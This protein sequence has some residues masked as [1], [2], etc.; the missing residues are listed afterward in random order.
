MT[1]EELINSYVQHDKAE[2]EEKEQK[3]LILK[4]LEKLAPHK[5]GEIVTWNEKTTRRSGGTMWNPE[6]E[7]KAIEKAAVLTSVDPRIHIWS[8][9]DVRF[10][11]NYSFKPIKKD[12]AISH[13][14]VYVRGN[15]ITW[16]GDIHYSYRYDKE[17]S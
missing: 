16:T 17:E 13:N 5:V 12:G 7:T 2:R 10:D 11:Y 15:D 1:K 6:Y 3:K 8:D 9:G 14:H 4:E